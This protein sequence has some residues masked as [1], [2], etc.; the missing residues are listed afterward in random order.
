MGRFL[1]I[2]LTQNMYK[3]WFFLLL[4]FSTLSGSSQCVS[5]FPYIENFEAGN[6]N[7]QSGGTADDWSWGAVSK[8]VITQ[9][10]SGNNCWIT[11]G[12]TSSF[13]NF[14][15][16]SYVESPCFDFSNLQYPHISFNI[17][18]ETERSYDGATFQ[19]SI[20]GGNS[21]LNLGAS[22]YVADCLNQNWFNSS[23][24]TSLSGLATAHDGWAGN[25]QNTNGSCLGGNGSGTWLRAQHCV[26]QLAGEQSV[27]FRFAFG[28]G[29]QCNAFDGFAFDDFTISETPQS[30]LDFTYTCIGS[31][32]SFSGTSTL[33]PSSFS[34][35]FGDGN[36]GSGLNVLHSYS[37]SASSYVTF[38]ANGA[39]GV[40][41]SVTK[42]VQMLGIVTN[43]DSVSCNGGTNGKAFVTVSGGGNY[44]YAWSTTP[45]Q[46]TDTAFNLS[47]GT[48]VVTVSASGFCDAVTNI[49]VAEPNAIA[50]TFTVVA[51]TCGAGVGALSANIIEGTTPYSYLWSNGVTGSNQIINLNVG[52]Y[53][54]TI[55]DA[56]NC[57]AVTQ[58]T[59]PYATG[60]FIQFD[61]VQNI[62]CG[63]TAD[64][65]VLA[66]VTGGAPPYNYLWSSNQVASHIVNLPQGTYYVTVTDVNN[67]TNTD[68]VII[69]SESCPSYLWFPTAFSPNGDGVNDFFKPKYSFDLQK[70]QMRVYNR[71]GELVF[72]TTNVNEGW[73][74]AYKNT[75]QPMSTYVWVADYVLGENKKLTSAGNV[76][77]V[78]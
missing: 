19:Y 71:W 11:G 34:W 76:T 64:G 5:A 1:L 3:A 7:W 69:T 53:T 63:E 77:L 72:E 66:T 27:V 28:A 42:Q 15:E 43:A 33:C 38:T 2:W 74:G 8:P 75:T 23:N 60:I 50:T 40:P 4:V 13:Y 25:I 18:W 35:N 52:T 10:A 68:S 58:E 16:R 55:T 49:E 51:D 24:I 65:E 30:V 21:W 56:N 59:V 61:S 9:A 26:R 36:F 12:T 78:R 22:N 48:Y 67:C 41:A 54:V 73:N 6:G 57:I 29:T 45:P 31:S 70:F 17:F 14:G 46:I 47:A 44:S 20:D 32:F 37:T 39:C 62:S